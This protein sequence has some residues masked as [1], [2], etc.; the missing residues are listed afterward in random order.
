[1]FPQVVAV[2][3]E[4]EHSDSLSIQLYGNHNYARQTQ[5]FLVA[6]YSPELG[7]EYVGAPEY[8]PWIW[9][10]GHAWVSHNASFDETVFYAARDHHH[11][12][13]SGIGPISW[14]CSADLSAFCLLGRSLESAVKNAYGITLSKSVR[15]KAKNKKWPTDFTPEQREEFQAYCLADSRWC[16]RL[17]TDY[18]PHWP[19]EE[20]A[21]SQIIRK[22]CAGGVRI[23]Q[24]L[25]GQYLERLTQLRDQAE[26][27]I[28]WAGGEN[29]VL[30]HKQVRAYCAL[31]DMP[32]PASLAEDS[33]ACAK[34]ESVYGDRFPIVGAIR[35]YRKANILL[36]KL[37]AVE[38]RL[39]PDGRMNFSLKYHGAAATGRLS[40]A[41]GWNIQNL[42]R[43]P[44]EGI[45]I[46][47]LLIAA[48]G[49]KFCVA[50]FSQ[51]EP[52]IIAWITGNETL[53][54]E[55]SGGQNFYEAEARLAGVWNG[56]SA[57]LKKTNLGLYQLQKSQSLGI[58][59]GMGAER[60]RAAAWEQ[61]GLEITSPLAKRVIR[62]WHTRNPGV[63]R[64]WNRLELEFRASWVKSEPYSMH[65]PSGRKLTYFAIEKKGNRFLASPSLEPRRQFYWGGSLFE[66]LIQA[67]ARDVL[68][69]A[70]LRLEDHGIPVIFSAHDEPVCEVDSNFDASE[71]LRL[72][73]APIA[74]A[75]GLPL[76]A[77]IN[78]VPAYT[79]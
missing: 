44:Y 10:D 56:E 53:L 12:I 24:A 60:Y 11:Q 30:S 42:G 27:R 52:R 22:R 23:D 41:D 40:G 32:A 18:S 75:P 49:K 31:Q 35:A 38:R 69:Q 21:F 26:E 63:R 76:A 13:P 20:R 46:R 4:S 29:P 79:K 55:L 59:Y 78:E 50:D 9:V 67:I 71:I 34:W 70:V 3:F 5:I 15:A 16:Y 54:K 39:M 73:T 2:D 1:M 65:L 8:A 33:Q 58:A 36:R 7:I 47:K 77:E 43:V 14:S 51:I 62:E 64:L 66:N 37:E 57:T 72:M 45:D 17:W 28:P 19:A 74:W 6:L 25:L 48:P 61:L 68:R